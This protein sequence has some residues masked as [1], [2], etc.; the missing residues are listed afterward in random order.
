[1]KYLLLILLSTLIVGCSKPEEYKFTIVVI[2]DGFY[3]KPDTITTVACEENDIYIYR[4]ALHNS[5][6]GGIAVGVR[7]FKI[8]NKQKQ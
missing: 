3:S 2:Y 5:W 8:I 4:G 7:T 1:M 6:Q